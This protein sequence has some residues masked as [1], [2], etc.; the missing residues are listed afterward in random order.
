MNI[1]EADW[2]EMKEYGNLMIGY[3]TQSI[4]LA[5]LLREFLLANNYKRIDKRFVGRAEKQFEEWK[6][7]KMIYPLTRIH[8]D[9]LLNKKYSQYYLEIAWESS[10][11]FA[12]FHFKER[13]QK[14]DSYRWPYM[15]SR[16]ESIP[17]HC[18]VFLGHNTEIDFRE[19]EGNYST[20]SMNQDYHLSQVDFYREQIRIFP[21]RVEKWNA[22]I[23]DLNQIKEEM[24]NCVKNT[25]Q[26]SEGLLR[27]LTD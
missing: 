13:W 27:F 18:R 4:H 23:K 16:K 5:P 15:K 25:D 12:A 10:S 19:I 21:D 24:K 1:K 14:V 22:T 2:E 17:I 11:T 26:Y 8:V 3:H 6:S 9:G 20:H 7:Q